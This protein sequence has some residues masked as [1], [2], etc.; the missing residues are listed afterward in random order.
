MD[1]TERAWAAGFFDAEGWAAAVKNRR[2]TR[3][4]AQINQADAFGVPEVLTRFQAAV[5]A[6]RIRGPQREPGKIDLYRWVASSQADVLR[7]YE[8]LSPWLGL[9]KA[10][11]FQK[12]I[13]P[14]ELPE[15]TPSHDEVLAWAAGLFDGDG[16]TCF[17]RHGSHAG[18]VRADMSITQSSRD[19]RPEVLV[20][21]HEIL[22]LGRINGPYGGSPAWEPVYR[23]KAHR[24]VDVETVARS[25]WPWL[26]TVKRVQA[27]I[28][29]GKVASQP[30]LPR[31]NPAWGRYKAHCVHG[32]E[33]VTARIRPFVGRKGGVEKRASKYCLACLRE[34]ARR[35]R[36][37][38][39]IGGSGE[40][41]T[42]AERANPYLL[43]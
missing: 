21:F 19:G 4:L 14:V 27:A 25:L 3:P 24:L 28:V 31:G 10:G 12:A 18:Y 23:W 2:G 15:H 39:W 16:S 11:Q 41:P 17:E 7:T 26:G 1:R 36:A 38:K 32:H 5:G 35:K 30:P 43:K 42:I 20:R 34:H 9:V 8:V 29:I 40:P 22:G 37:Q 33:Y 13:G 6:G